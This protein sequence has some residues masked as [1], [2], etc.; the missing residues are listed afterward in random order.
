MMQA[1][2]PL[3]FSFPVEQAAAFGFRLSALS[4]RQPITASRTLLAPRQ[5]KKL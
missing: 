4:N 2:Y 1:R 3:T 5:L